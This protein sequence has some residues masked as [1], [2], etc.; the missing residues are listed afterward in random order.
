[1]AMLTESVSKPN[2]HRRI[3]ALA[4]KLRRRQL[5]GS[6]EVAL[7]V[8]RLLREVVAGA[9]FN[10]FE[11]LTA[12]IDEVGK[13]LQD[14]GPKELV[15]T[16]MCRRIAVLMREEYATALS[17]HLD[18]ALS[19]S[20]SPST[21][22]VPQT[23]AVA[24]VPTEP[25]FHHER[26]LIGQAKSSGAL[27]SMFDL[28]GHRPTLE[29]VPSSNPRGTASL[30]S[31]PASSAPP[32]PKQQSP[33]SSQ[34]LQRP[35]ALSRPSVDTS[36]VREEE[37]SRRSFHLKPVFIEAIQ[38]LMDEVEMTYRSVGE[39]SIDHIHSGEFILT[40]GHSKTVEAFLKNAARKRKFTVIVAET[41]PSFS[42]RETALALSAASIPTILIPDSNIF[43]LLPRCSK[44]LL[45][46]HVVLADGALLSISGS[47]PLCL[48]ANR[49][50]VP[51]VVVGGMFKFSPVYFGEGDWGMRDLGSPEQVLSSTEF[52]PVSRVTAPRRRLRGDGQDDGDEAM[53][54]EDEEED[55][56]VLNPYYDVVSADLVSLYI[57]NLGG[58]PSS[59]LY[60]LLNDM[61]G[62]S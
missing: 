48:A 21:P 43:A 47:L 17:N 18:S 46:P 14:A 38:E 60:R 45:G 2:V 19:P 49:M 56:E 59:L 4:T 29:G 41:A 50:R 54:D 51:V 30:A 9:K 44:V 34:I 13:V 28:L 25:F 20:S 53:Y 22:Q 11:Q 12:H 6:R 33:A 10:S 7:E 58:H 1:M 3:Q 57:S 52:P 31:T 39:Q 5:V 35:A 8:I 26:D 15:V 36:A 62:S 24:G 27:S 37:F 40:I 42:G 23:P 61:Y 16:N 32:S 55:T